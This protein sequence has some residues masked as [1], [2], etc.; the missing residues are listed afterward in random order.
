MTT[1]EAWHRTITKMAASPAGAL[2]NWKELWL[3]SWTVQILKAHLEFCELSTAGTKPT[4]ISCLSTYINDFLSDQSA[5]RGTCPADKASIIH[6]GELL[7]AHLMSNTS[8]PSCLTHL[9]Y[10]CLHRIVWLPDPRAARQ[11]LQRPDARAGL[12]SQKVWLDRE[13]LER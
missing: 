2:E 3:N 13:D 10:T 11:K 4:L 12:G 9:R 6:Y 7:Q 5:P 8:C 1:L